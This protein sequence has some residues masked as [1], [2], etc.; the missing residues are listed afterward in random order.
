VICYFDIFELF[1]DG[2]VAWR[3][4]GSDRE[5]ALRK[6][7]EQAALTENEVRLLDIRSKEIIASVN[8]PSASQ[9]QTTR[10][11]FKAASTSA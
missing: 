3:G 7:E 1:P 10:L 5:D 11:R 4:A 6:L 8:S 9:P 2:S